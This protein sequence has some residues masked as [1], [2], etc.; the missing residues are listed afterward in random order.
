MVK[1]RSW[2][3]SHGDGANLK[4]VERDLEQ[5]FIGLPIVGRAQYTDGTVALIKTLC[6][7]DPPIPSQIFTLED[8]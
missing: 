8:F 7:N 2:K 5:K 1:Y 4:A 6:A 3:I